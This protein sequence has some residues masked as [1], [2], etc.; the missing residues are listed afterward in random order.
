MKQLSHVFLTILFAGMCFTF[1]EKEITKPKLIAYDIEIAK[2]FNNHSAAITLT[3]DTGSPQ[4]DR[5]RRVTDFVYEHG[6][7]MDF[8][9]VSENFQNRPEMRE[10]F[11]NTLVPLGFGCFGHGHTHVNHDALSYEDAY[12]SFKSCY[13]IMLSYGIKPVSFAYPKGFGYEEETQ[14]ALKDAGFLCGRLHSRYDTANPFILPDGETDFRNWYE[15][16]SLVMR[17]FEFDHCD[18]CVNNTDE[19]IEILDEAINRHAW[20]VLTYHS[21]GYEEGYGYY[22]WDEFVKNVQAIVERD[23]FND[24]IDDIMLYIKER[25]NIQI[26]SNVLVNR[27][28]LIEKI[29]ITLTDGLPNDYY[30]QPLTVIFDVPKN[31]NGQS[32]GVFKNDSLLQELTLDSPTGKLSLLPNE[33]AYC[34]SLIQ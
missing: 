29:N 22:Y 20:I 30:N 18:S 28:D 31:W 4:I 24:S 12:F 26:E 8:E 6:L 25:Q 15:M 13:D 3:Y 21:I 23:F 5:E 9:L 14:Q 10:Y 19:L 16:P 11:L 7:R 2:W 34:L 33:E 27:N 17:A 1:C 32:V